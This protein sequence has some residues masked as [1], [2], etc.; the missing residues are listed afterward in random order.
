[1]R[2]L[3]VLPARGLAPVQRLQPKSGQQT[4]LYQGHD[5][6][7]W[8][9]QL[10][11]TQTGTWRLR[12]FA[13]LRLTAGQEKVTKEVPWT[14][15]VAPTRDVVIEFDPTSSTQY[16]LTNYWQWIV[17]T[18][19]ALLVPTGAVIGWNDQAQAR[20]GSSAGTQ[21]RHRIVV[22]SRLA[23]PHTTPQ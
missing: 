17:G 9:W 8:K 10:S 2:P 20:F 19:I 18:L 16:V 4:L 22:S 21:G 1:V 12:L 5:F 14:T 7:E 11:A 13:Y 23:W 3:Y 6:A 15:T